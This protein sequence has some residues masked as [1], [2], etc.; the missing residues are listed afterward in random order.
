MEDSVCFSWLIG[1]YCL[2]LSKYYEFV[3]EIRDM[4]FG[5]RELVKV[6]GCFRSFW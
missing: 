3:V 2:V 1:R 5:L 4:F 6:K